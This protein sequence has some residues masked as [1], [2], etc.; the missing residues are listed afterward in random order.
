MSIEFYL[1]RI[2]DEHKTVFSICSEFLN[3]VCVVEEEEG[4]V[5]LAILGVGETQGGLDVHVCSYEN[6]HFIEFTHNE[7][8]HLGGA[9]FEI[10]NSIFLSVASEVLNNSFHQTF[11]HAH[12]VLLRESHL[13]EVMSFND[14]DD[15]LT[16][17]IS[18]SL[19]V[20]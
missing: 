11:H 2:I 6:L 15:G 18:W 7:F 1:L 20:S 17:F 3:F 10:W 4:W 8:N 5:G 9:L 19:I 14:I 13:I 12:D 16:L